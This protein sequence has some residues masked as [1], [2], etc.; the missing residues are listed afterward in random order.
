MNKVRRALRVFSWGAG[1]VAFV[2]VAIW[3]VSAIQRNGEREEFYKKESARVIALANKHP[4]QPD[5]RISPY[6][7]AKFK[8][9]CQSPGEAP[10]D[11]C[12]AISNK[13]VRATVRYTP[14]ENVVL[15]NG[16][17]KETEWRFSGHYVRIILKSDHEWNEARMAYKNKEKHAKK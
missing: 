15:I 4:V 14:E 12:F 13:G 3:A 9:N 11:E 7:L 16:Q 5:L 2:S 1:A 6:D 10:D 17:E 8:E